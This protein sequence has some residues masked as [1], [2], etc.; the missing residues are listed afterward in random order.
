MWLLVKCSLV[1]DPGIAGGGPSPPLFPLLGLADGGCIPSSPS[2]P[3]LLVMME[4]QWQFWLATSGGRGPMASVIA[5]AYNGGLGAEPP[6]VSRV[7]ALG[8]EVKEPKP[9]KAKSLFVS[10][11]SVLFQALGP[12]RH[13]THKNIQQ[14][15][16]QKTHES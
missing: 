10:S 3:P 7:G 13:K 14:K 9:P 15:N 12:Y 2:D 5:Q 8:K 16:T 4:R 11:S 1:A 6:A